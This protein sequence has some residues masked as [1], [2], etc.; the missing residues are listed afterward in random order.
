M[1]LYNDSSYT[2]AD[3]EKICIVARSLLDDELLG[4]NPLKNHVQS[5]KS[6]ISQ[7]KNKYEKMQSY[8]LPEINDIT[9]FKY[10][11]DECAGAQVSYFMKTSGGSFAKTFQ[12]FLLRKDP[13]GKWKIY[14]F[15]EVDSTVK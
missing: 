6:E 8:T 2:D 7:F 14:G 15:K 1:F 5:L 13:S 9:Y 3:L 4:N 10:K 11:G 12:D